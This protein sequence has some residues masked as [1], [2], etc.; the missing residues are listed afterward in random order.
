MTASL[1]KENSVV[2]DKPRSFSIPRAPEKVTE[3][4]VR[5]TRLLFKFKKLFKFIKII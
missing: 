2:I 3:F 4:E 1:C 5:D